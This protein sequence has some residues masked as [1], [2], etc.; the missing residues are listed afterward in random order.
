MYIQF[1]HKNNANKLHDIKHT[2]LYKRNLDKRTVKKD[3]QYYQ[4][5]KTSQTNKLSFP[6]LMFMLLYK[7]LNK[8]VQNMLLYTCCCVSYWGLA[9]S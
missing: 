8:T 1:I 6:F 5:K 9:G 3:I 7:K 2:S 4:K